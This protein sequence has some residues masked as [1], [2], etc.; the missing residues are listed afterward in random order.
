MVGPRRTQ[1][2]ASFACLLELP[3]TAPDYDPCDAGPSSETDVWYSAST[4]GGDTCDRDLLSDGGG[5]H[6]WFPWA[7]HTPDGTTSR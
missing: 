4:D 6:Q 7:D 3:G 5:A 2:N 1:P